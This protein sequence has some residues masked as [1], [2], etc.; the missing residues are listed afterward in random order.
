[1]APPPHVTQQYRFASG[2]AWLSSTGISHQDLLPQIPSIHPSVIKSSPHPG[3]AP[4]SLNSSSQ[5][6]RLPGDQRSCLRC[7]WFR[8]GLILIPFRLPQISCFTLSLKYF[9]SDSD[10]CPDVGMGPLLQFPHPWRA[11][12]ILLTLVFPPSSFILLSFVWFYIFLS[13]GQG[14]LSTLRWSSACTSVSQGVLLIY[15]WGE[16]CCTSTHSPAVC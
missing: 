2:A 3:I 11:G 13:T 9:S 14:L 16:R 4:Q 10:N 1:M 12:P 7:V 15:P 5:P 6:L 8:Q